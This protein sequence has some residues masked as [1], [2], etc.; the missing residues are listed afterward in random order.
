[1]AQRIWLGPE[2][3]II[4]VDNRTHTPA[5]DR[6]DRAPGAV[7]TSVVAPGPTAG[8]AGSLADLLSEL[9]RVAADWNPTGRASIAVVTP[10]GALHGVNENRPHVSASA[11]KALWTA[12]A[13]DQAGAGAVAPLAHATLALSDNHAAGSVIDLIGI[14]AVNT[15]TRNV[16]GLT[17]TQVASWPYGNRR[18]SQS[19]IDGAGYANQTTAADLARFYALLHGNELL[20]ADGTAAL[21]GW[22]RDTPRGSGSSATVA[23]A[24]LSRLPPTVAAEAT[25]KA[26]WLPP[27]CCR[28]DHR[29]IIDAGA[30][31]LPGGDWFAIAAVA[32]RG[33]DYNLSIRWVAYA[34]CRVHKLLAADDSLSC[35]RAG[36]GSS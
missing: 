34:A 4:V 26:G 29:L 25:H 36:D 22:L 31:P 2:Q 1:M 20:S 28:N 8:G 12:A 17:G 32:D 21:V 9:V 30:I 35:D 24:L 6:R 14:D 19:A 7:T 13:I 5:G 10:D 3:R 16:A 18:V 15:W 11:V 27:N 23:G 33:Q